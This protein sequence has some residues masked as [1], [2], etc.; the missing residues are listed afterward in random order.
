MNLQPG[1]SSTRSCRFEIAF[2]GDG[3]IPALGK[4]NGVRRADNAVSSRAHVYVLYND[5]SV[6][7]TMEVEKEV[8]EV[9][10]FHATPR[11]RRGRASSYRNATAPMSGPMRVCGREG[12]RVGGSRQ[13]LTTDVPP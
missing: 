10:N 2:V 7:E 6:G 13:K 9:N 1:L 8:E 4:S 11:R 5:G 3:T 12:G